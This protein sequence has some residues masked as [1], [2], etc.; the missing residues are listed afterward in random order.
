MSDFGKFLFS[1]IRESLGA[2][3]WQ[4]EISSPESQEKQI[5]DREQTKTINSCLNT[6]LLSTK[7]W[8]DTFMLAV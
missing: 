1:V 8:V 7:L 2:S 5:N 4:V 3:K 6:S